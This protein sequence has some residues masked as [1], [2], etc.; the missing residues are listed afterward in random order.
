V[1]AWSW[2]NWSH[3]NGRGRLL[4]YRAGWLSLQGKGNS[5]DLYLLNIA[6]N[7]WFTC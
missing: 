2:G 7:P 4:L 5:L 1:E 6:T 3:L